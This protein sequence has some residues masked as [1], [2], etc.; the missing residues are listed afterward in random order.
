[1]G[2][3]KKIQPEEMEAM[4]RKKWKRNPKKSAFRLRGRRVYPE[5]INRYI[6]EYPMQS[7]GVYM[8]NIGSARMIPATS[9]LTWM[10][11]LTSRYT[12]SDTGS[13]QASPDATGN[14]QYTYFD[15]NNGPHNSDN[16]LTSTIPEKVDIGSS[17]EP[18]TSAPSSSE[19]NLTMAP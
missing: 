16:M 11:N 7:F 18:N 19:Q 5:K 13:P 15:R 4:I 6:K 10:N 14:P 12:P 1:M 9:R 2:L 8:E 17:R 3:N